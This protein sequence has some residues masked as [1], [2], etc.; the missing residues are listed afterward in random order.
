MSIKYRSRVSQYTGWVEFYCG[1]SIIWQIDHQSVT[2]AMVVCWQCVGKPLVE[3]QWGIEWWC[4]SWK[5]ASPIQPHPQCFALCYKL[6][7]LS[8]DTQKTLFAH[9]TYR[10]WLI[11]DWSVT[12]NCGLFSCIGQH[13]C[14]LLV[15]I[16]VALNNSRPR[17]WSLCQLSV[18]DLLVIRRRSNDWLL[19]DCWPM[20]YSGWLLVETRS[21]LD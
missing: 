19:T 21:R 7:H 20:D 1:S 13:L 9:Y 5:S 17:Y 3:F 15:D 14:H 11:P 12:P 18:G 16:S 6:R 8:D 4:I 2:I 10:P